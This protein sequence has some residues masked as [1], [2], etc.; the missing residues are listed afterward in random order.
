[1]TKLDA[2]RATLSDICN[3]FD[4]DSSVIRLFHEELAGYG[5]A[6][7]LPEEIARPIITEYAQIAYEEA[8]D[9]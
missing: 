8:Y 6:D 2:T 5:V 1:M 7:I 9:I 3:W 4:V